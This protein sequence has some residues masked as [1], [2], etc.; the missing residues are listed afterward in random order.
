MSYLGP[1]L[2]ALRQLGGSGTPAEVA[3]V[4]AKVLDLSDTVL[5]ELI[6]S[7]ESRYRNQLQWA[8][9]YLSRAG[10]IGSSKR[11]I[12]TLT[13][14]GR[15]TTLDADQAQDVYTTVLKCYLAARQA[16]KVASPRDDASA[17]AYSAGSK[18]IT[19]PIDGVSIGDG[20]RIAP[21]N[22]LD[23]LPSAIDNVDRY[24]KQLLER[25]RN[26]TPNGF[27]RITQRI[28]RESGFSEVK[29][30]GKSGDGG[31]D[32]SGT[33]SL[34][35][36]V[37]I[38][39]L[40]QCKKYQGSVG[41]PTVRDFRGAMQG[42]AEYGLILTTGIFTADARREASRDG[43]SPIELIDGERLID[44]M[45]DLQLGLVPIQTFAVDEGFFQ[46][47]MD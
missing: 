31:I 15:H 4:V 13:D 3:N 27:E 30:T 17:D 23:V 6:P 8:R 9:Y 11:G 41:S 42:R 35:K 12:W 39:V 32:G 40:F 38:Q 33:L 47:F 45:K 43:V 44:L 21:Q 34:N 2:D 1:V 29:V 14:M 36:L 22:E 28:L 7:G 10:L 26:L 46:G 18:Q 25:I 20:N 19:P 16:D 24:R 5:D 37:S